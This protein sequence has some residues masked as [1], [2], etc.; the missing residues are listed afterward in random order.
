MTIN[1]NDFNSFAEFGRTR[2]AQTN[3]S[4]DELVVEWESLQ[5]RDDI[6]AAIAEGLEDIKAGRYR[7]ADEVM[8]DLRKKHNLPTE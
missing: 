4:L 6:N 7:P 8:V 3:L 1:I 5:N 2:L